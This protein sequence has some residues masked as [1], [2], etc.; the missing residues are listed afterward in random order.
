MTNKITRIVTE[1][2][3]ISQI[4]LTFCN[5]NFDQERYSRIMEI[6]AELASLHSSKLPS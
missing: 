3:A 6:S 4:G 2:Q 1:L 5:D